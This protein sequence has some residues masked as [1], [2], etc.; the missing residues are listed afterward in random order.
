MQFIGSEVG[1]TPKEPEGSILLKQF[2][3][4]SVIELDDKA[5]GLVREQFARTL[6]I[7]LCNVKDLPGRK[8]IAQG[9]MR[10]FQAPESGPH[11]AAM[12]TLVHQNEEDLKLIQIAAL[13]V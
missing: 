10:G 8:Q 13:G 3:A 9:G 12:P 5:R 11:T 4:D 7:R 1:K 6:Q 2:D